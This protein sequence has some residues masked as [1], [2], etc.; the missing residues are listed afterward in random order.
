MENVSSESG[1]IPR[2][3]IAELRVAAESVVL[4]VIRQ[5]PCL[6]FTM[7]QVSSHAEAKKV[8][9]A[10]GMLAD[11]NRD[12]RPIIA[13]A[14]AKLNKRLRTFKVKIEPW[15]HRDDQLI[16]ILNEDAEW[17]DAVSEAW[18]YAEN[19]NEFYLT[20]AALGLLQFLRSGDLDEDFVSERSISWKMGLNGREHC[21]EPYL[22]EVAT[23]A[24]IPV[25]WEGKGTRW[26]EKPTY[27]LWIDET[28]PQP[29]K[30]PR[31]I[32]PVFEMH[33]DRFTKGNVDQARATIHE[34]LLRLNPNGSDEIYL[35]AIT[36]RQELRHCFPNAP[37]RESDMLAEFFSAVSLNQELDRG[38]DFREKAPMW[39]VT[40]SPK[41]D[42]P[43]ALAAIRHQQDQPGLQERFGLTSDA[44]KLL[45]WIEKL[46]NDKKLLGRVT[47]IVEDSARK[48]IG[49]EFPWSQEN[50]AVYLQL[51]IDEINERTSYDLRL[52]PW[53]EYGQ[54]KSRISIRRKPTQ[55][56]A[57]V[58]Q[59]RQ[60]SVERGNSLGEAEA[61]SGIERLLAT[62]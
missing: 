60:I 9:K 20:N 23:K 53:R 24:N 18:S 35:I 44:A 3:P 43:T 50:A 38:Y 15:S 2:K 34:T 45:E 36:S 27:R 47:P 26:G 46:S 4:D 62:T 37:S 11:D 57:L 58:S 22:Y 32:N 12:V 61:R 33:L 14:V 30:V 52:L 56:D 42:W 7:D 8:R 49:I 41:T 39:S 6:H 5:A 1:K 51:L 13:A 10:I 25:Q 31:G 28:A 29:A 16:A 54:L 48:W 40:L 59:I 21:I 55:I 19:P 17:A